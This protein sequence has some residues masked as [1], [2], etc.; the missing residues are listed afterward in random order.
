VDLFF[1]TRQLEHAPS[2]YFKQGRMVA[3]VE[4]PNRPEVMARALADAGALRRLVP[5]AGMAPIAAVHADHYLSFLASAHARMIEQGGWGPEMLPNV[6]PYRGADDAFRGRSAPRV[7]GLVGL[8]G[9]YMGD[10]SCALSAGTWTSAYWSAQTAVAAADA[11]LAGTNAAFALCRP[12][13][14]HA[15]ADRASGFCFLNNAAIATERLFQ[16]YDRIAIVDFDTHHGDGTQAIFYGREDVLFASVHTDPSVYYPWFVGYADECGAGAGEGATLNV[17][18][19]PG[20]DDGA[21]VRAVAQLARAVA[22]FNA[23]ALV[24]SAGWDAHR[25][26]PLSVL[27]VGSGAFDRI[28]RILRELRL[29]TVVVQEGGYSLAAIAECAPAFVRAFTDV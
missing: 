1:D 25:A 22:D 26:D 12:P 28:G 16:R 20:A 6:H 27:D 2:Q 7:T 17:P 10:M 15:Y 24:I 11:V 29:P 4:N 19:P 8:A 21:Y 5:D 18:L 9:W 3:P 14:H 13:G 23:D